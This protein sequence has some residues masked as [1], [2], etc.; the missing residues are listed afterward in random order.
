MTVVNYRVKDIRALGFECKWSKR[1]GAPILVVRDP[2]AASDHQRDKWWVLDEA[3]WKRAQKVGLKQAF[4][5]HT[6][7]G[8]FFSVAR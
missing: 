5:E 2:A 7:L 6:A 1:R 8:N 3:M 4:D